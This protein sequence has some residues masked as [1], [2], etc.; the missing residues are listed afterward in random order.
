MASSDEPKSTSVLAAGDAATILKHFQ[1][2]VDNFSN[3][4]LI[5]WSCKDSCKE[6]VKFFTP[7]EKREFKDTQ[8]EEDDEPQG[9]PKDPQANH[10][11]DAPSL[12]AVD[13]PKPQDDP[14]DASRDASC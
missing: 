12:S 13:L 9:N 3:C 7:A 5:V 11:T 4:V 6:F 8:K 10:D 14:R 2:C 1:I